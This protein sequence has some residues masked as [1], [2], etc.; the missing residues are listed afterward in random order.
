MHFYAC[1]SKVELFAKFT[2]GQL[3]LGKANEANV[4]Q[5]LLRRGL[6]MLCQSDACDCSWCPKICSKHKQAVCLQKCLAKVILLLIQLCIS[7]PI[8][9]KP[10]CSGNS[11]GCGLTLLWIPHALLPSYTSSCGPLCPHRFNSC[12]CFLSCSSKQKM[13]R[14]LM[15]IHMIYMY[16]ENLLF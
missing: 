6:K 7:P 12:L 1:T 14:S 3:F 13:S 5:W 16:N 8:C 9:W 11:S 4:W 2:Q 15:Q 10:T